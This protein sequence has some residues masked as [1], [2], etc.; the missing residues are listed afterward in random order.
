MQEWEYLVISRWWGTLGWYWVDDKKLKLN[1]E[2]RLNILGQKGW[3]LVSV[4]PISDPDLGG[5]RGGTPRIDFY[6]KR[7]VDIDDANKS[8]S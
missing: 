4:S 8:N 7:A 6:F 3:M 5:N 2:E 1:I